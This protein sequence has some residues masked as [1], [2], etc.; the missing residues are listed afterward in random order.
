ML[1]DA[2]FKQIISELDE[3]KSNFVN[4]LFTPPTSTE[5]SNLADTDDRV[6]VSPD[7][8][9]L[10]KK[11]ALKTHPDKVGDSLSEVFAKINNSYKNNDIHSLRMYCDLLS[12]EQD[13][14]PD[15]EE[16]EDLRHKINHVAQDTA[17]MESSWAYVWS[18]EK[19][20]DIIYEFI[21]GSIK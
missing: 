1:F 21:K 15:P 18:A 12:L 17:N 2:R 13:H 6:V 5:E 8:K 20:D 10:Y 7:V 9:R 4:S 3:D 16:C 11:L 19:D 14:D